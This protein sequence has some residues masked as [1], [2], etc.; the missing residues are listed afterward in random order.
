MSWAGAARDHGSM[1]KG[2][3]DVVLCGDSTGERAGGMKCTC[4]DLTAQGFIVGFQ[5]LWVKIGLHR[6]HLNS[7]P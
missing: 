7:W 1:P 3:G 6:G 2:S 5:L 4:L